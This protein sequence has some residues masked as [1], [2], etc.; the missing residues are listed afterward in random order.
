MTRS[1]KLYV[2]RHF[3]TLSESR[4]QAPQTICTSMHTL[5]DILKSTNHQISEMQISKNNKN[6]KIV[7][8]EYV[9]SLHENNFFFNKR[10][11][12][13]ILNYKSFT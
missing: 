11:V 2:H 13:W 5:R 4:K 9:P 10:Q 3:Q 7:Q 8:L 12:T 6:K 1:A